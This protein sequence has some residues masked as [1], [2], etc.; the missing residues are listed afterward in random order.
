MP[1]IIT[2]YSICPKC[3]VGR[4]SPEPQHRP[5]DAHLVHPGMAMLHCYNFN[6]HQIGCGYAVEATE[7]SILAE[8]AKAEVLKKQRLHADAVAKD[9]EAKA[10]AASAT[11]EAA[12]LALHSAEAGAGSFQTAAEATADNKAEAVRESRA[13]KPASPSADAPVFPAATISD[14]KDTA[15][16]F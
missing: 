1:D 10:K 6:L 16:N 11:A 5:K 7:P 14:P 12:K 2:P 4:L 3:S 15:D 9:L 13:P 8:V